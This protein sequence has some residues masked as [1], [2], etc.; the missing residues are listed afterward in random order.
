MPIALGISGACGRMG[1]TIAGLAFQEKAFAVASA[2]EVGGHPEIGQDYGSLLGLSKPLGVPVTSDAASAI[3]KIDVLIEFT[4][5]E[6]TVAHA[7]MARDLKKP[8]VIGTTGLSDQQLSALKAC[9]SAIPIVFSPNMSVGVNVLF[10]VAK[11]AV[12]RLGLGYDVE[13]VEAHHKAKKDAPSGTAKR[14]VEVL[15]SAR[16]Q[17]PSQVPAHAVR[18]GDIVGDHTV[19]LAGPSERLELTH[20]AQSRSVFAQ[21]AL[22]AAVFIRSQ[23]PG[24]YDMADVL[25]G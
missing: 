10:E 5:P 21:G 6:V 3:G 19:I 25:K 15:A 12:E 18:A 7:Q 14:L 17:Q 20:R 1:R 22:R 8:I 2:I 9:A 24:F 4:I 23:R 13:V 16:K 11:L